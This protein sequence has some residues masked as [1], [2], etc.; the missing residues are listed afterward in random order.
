MKQNISS[1]LAVWPKS[2]IIILTVGIIFHLIN[3]DKKVYWFDEVYTSFRVS[4][5]QG[6]EIDREIFQNKIITN[7]D[8]SKFLSPNPNS[9]V[10]DTIQSLVKEDPQHPPLYFVINRF[11]NKVF[12]NSVLSYRSLAVLFSLLCLPFMYGLAKKL[13]SNQL[14]AIISS[15]LLA[16]SPFD[17]LFAQTARQ[18]S[19]LSL[20]TVSSSYFL[21]KACQN[22]QLINWILY[23]FVCVLGFYSHPFFILTIMG[24]GVFIFSRYWLEKSQ[25]Q[26]KDIKCFLAG[27]AVA[28]ILYLPWIWVIIE[29][30]YRVNTTTSWASQGR[31]LLYL[32]KLWILSFS[33]LLFDLD[34]GFNNPLTYLARLPFILQSIL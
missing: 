23:I 27:I 2:L 13:F 1:K 17:I 26:G 33:S 29:Q 15:I 31:D 16:W 6:K 4:G 9:S 7:N 14:T 12:G 11:W 10:I 28:I 22:S 30:K 24:H 34:F 19:L 3:I 32:L 8:L 25:Q 21:L 5:Y 20:A 18:Y